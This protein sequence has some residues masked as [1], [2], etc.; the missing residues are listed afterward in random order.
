[1]QFQGDSAS[2]TSREVMVSK[3]IAQSALT[4]AD[5][6]T[7]A[8]FRQALRNFQHHSEENVRAAHLTPQ[9]HQALLVL[10][11]GYPGNAEITVTD[12]AD[13]LLLKHHSAVELVGRLVKAGFVARRTSDSDRRRVMISLTSAGDEVL[14][15]LSEAHLYVLQSAAPVLSDLLRLLK[16][17][18]FG[19]MRA[20]RAG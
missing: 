9:Q 8:A 16:R 12:L 13:A 17:H 11:G 14:L 20:R 10:K 18:G 2:S 6:E 4:Q 1:M 3:D 7:L 15:S 5:Y 19:S